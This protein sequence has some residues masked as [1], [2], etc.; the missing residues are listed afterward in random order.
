VGLFKKNGL[1]V[2]TT[3]IPQKDRHLAIACGDVQGGFNQSL[4]HIQTGGVDEVE[5]T[6]VGPIATGQAAVTSRACC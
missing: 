6:E 5:E 4:Q 1:D 3:K 2:S